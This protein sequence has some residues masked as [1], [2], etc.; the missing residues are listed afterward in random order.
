MFCPHRG[1]PH[2]GLQQKIA[3]ADSVKDIHMWS[4]NSVF[5]N[6]IAK[7]IQMQTNYK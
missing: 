6:E 7:N 4:Q 3:V 1:H 2:G 5:S